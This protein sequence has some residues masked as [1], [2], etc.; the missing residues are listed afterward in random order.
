MTIFLCNQ[1]DLFIGG[2]DATTATIEWA[3]AELLHNPEKMAKVKQELVENVGS[4][5]SVKEADIMQL[6]YLDEVQKETMRLNTTKPLPIH[7]AETDVQLWG[8]IIPKQT[9]VRGKERSIRRD[10]G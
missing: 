6:T 2:T 7:S 3:M 10:A 4:G 8:L 5:F 1:Q 9:Q